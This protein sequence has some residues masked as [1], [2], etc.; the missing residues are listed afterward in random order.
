MCSIDEKFPNFQQF[1][2]KDAKNKTRIL[3]YSTETTTEIN[4]KSGEKKQTE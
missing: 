1:Q 3:N 4:K 2:L